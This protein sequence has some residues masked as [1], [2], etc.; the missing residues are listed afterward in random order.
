V[1]AACVGCDGGSPGAVGDVVTLSARLLDTLCSARTACGD[2]PDKATCQASVRIDLGQIQA[3]VSAG[4]VIY[5]PTQADACINAIAT[6]VGSCRV[7]E[8]LS[9]AAAPCNRMFT[10]TVAQG[11]A[12]F[13]A[14]ECVSGACDLTRCVGPACCAGTCL[15]A[16]PQVQLG[17]SCNGSGQCVAGTFCDVNRP[18]PT[19]AAVKAEGSPCAGSFSECAAGTECRPVDAQ[20][21]SLACQKLPDEGQACTP[22][23]GD[24]D[25]LTDFCDQTTATCKPRL[26]LG[27]PCSTAPVDDCVGYATC[28]GLSGKCVALGRVG[29]D[30]SLALGP[31]CL[32]SLECSGSGTCELPPAGPVCQ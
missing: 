21:T 13:M 28:D 22:T 30:C 14:L 8:G 25:L 26:G 16:E 6:S 20:G 32:P 4:K 27:S 15:P 23:L 17:G 12:C 5:D 7:S 9:I 19:C 10:G 2:Y 29:D 24:C 11:G 1:L 3:D 18:T 31:G